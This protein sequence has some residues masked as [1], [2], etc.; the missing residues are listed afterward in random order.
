M[1][2]GFLPI[3]DDTQESKDAVLPRERQGAVFYLGE[4]LE[5]KGGRFSVNSIGKEMIVLRGLPGTD[6]KK[7]E[8]VTPM[9]LCDKIKEQ[10]RDIPEHKFKQDFQ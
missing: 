6:L 8:P 2:G 7:C 9:E 10:M 3:I 4:I 5:I 1:T